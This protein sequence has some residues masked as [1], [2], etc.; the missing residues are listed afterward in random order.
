MER[1]P[2]DYFI[3]AFV[4]KLQFLIESCIDTTVRPGHTE[5][6]HGQ[7]IG[8]FRFSMRLPCAPNAY[9]LCDRALKKGGGGYLLPTVVTT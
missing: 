8:F 9:Y 6:T 5:G 7:R 2:F 1:M 3:I 4:S